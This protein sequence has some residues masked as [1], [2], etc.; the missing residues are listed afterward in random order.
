MSSNLASS[1]VTYTSISSHG[2]T[3]AWAVD[4]FGLREPDSPE[5]AP[6]SPDYVSSPEE[7]EQVPPSPYY[8]PEDPEEDSEDGLVDYLADRGDDDDDDDSSN[9][10]EEDEAEEEEEHQASADFVIVPTVDPVPSFEETDPFKTDESAVTP[11]PPPTD[12]V[13]AEILLALPA[14]PPSPLISLSPPSANECLARCL[15]TPALPSSLYSPPPVPISLPLLLPP[16]P[17]LPTSLFIPPLV[18]RREDIPEVELPPHKRLC[19]TT[20]TSRYEAR[21]SSTAAIPTGDLT[22]VVEEIAPMTL[23]E[24]NARVTE[25]VERVNVLTKD[26]EFHQETV[27]MME[28]EALVSRE[29]WHTALRQ[30]QALQARDPT[31]A[32]DPEGID[33][34]AQNNMPP[35]R[36]SATARAATAAGASMTAT[37][38]EQLIKAKA[39]EFANDQMDQKVLTI[40]ERQDEQKRKLEFDAGNNQGHQ[41]QNKR[42]N[43]KRAYTVGP[44]EKREYMKSLPLCIK[45]NY[46]HKGPCAPRCNRC[47]KIGHLTR[48]YRSSG[49]NCNNTNRWNYRM[50]QNASTCYECGVQGHFKRDCSKLKNKNHDSNV[51]TGAF[52]LNNLYASILFD[53]GVDRSFV[54]TTFSSLIDIAPTTLDHYYDVKLADG[55]IIRIHTIIQGCTLNFLDHLFNIDLMPVELCS[56]DVITGMDWLAKYHAVI[57]C[58]EKIVRIPWGNETL[59]VHGDE[60]NQGNETRLNINSCTKTYKTRYGH[61][62]F[63]VMPFG[64]TNAPEIFM[65]LTNRVC[66]PYLDK[67]VI[68]FI[69]DILIYSKNKEE[70]EEYLKLILELLKKEELYAKFS[71]CEFWIPKKELNM[72]K[73]YWLEFLSD[74]DYKIRYHPGKENVVADALSMKERIKPLR[75]GA[76]VIRRCR[77]YDQEGSTKGEVGTTYG[78][79]LMLT[80]QELVTLLWRSEDCDYARVSLV[81]ILYLSRGRTFWQAGELN[82]RYV[83][84]FKMLEKVGSIA[85][86]LELPQELSRVHSTFHVSNLKKCYSEEPLTIPLDGLHTD[87]KLHFMKEP[88]EIMDREVRRLK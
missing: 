3:L 46:H 10:D 85:Y 72:R 24:V 26:R 58:A 73:R 61:Y 27:F 1:K 20:P 78:W 55:K 43:N 81:K 15:A 11:P 57:V 50:T 12:Q 29:A 32:Y 30:I 38:V 74:Y 8:V 51:V 88:I 9:D 36:T 19:L 17:P 60:S 68:V 71:K 2:D 31:H 83:G 16:L 53:T 34:C 59:I 7:P 80:W 4:F 77:R 56:F 47:K 18:D 28:Q 66:K 22:E 5:A 6:A 42:Q 86:R 67:F 37:V 76:L 21:E 40:T 41:Q 63:Q 13:E 48:D 65:E 69:D 39:I 75:F 84:P 62:E 54:S 23:E 35:K 25:I 33:S 70:N 64:L 44:S 52:L 14:P 49:P 45:Y 87:D 79:N 82:P